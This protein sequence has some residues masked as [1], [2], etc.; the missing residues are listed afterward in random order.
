MAFL[1]LVIL[2][3]AGFVAYKV[4]Q[5]APQVTAK[6]EEIS[7]TPLAKELKEVSKEIEKAAEKPVVAKK[8]EPSVKKVSKEGE[9]TAKKPK[10]K[11]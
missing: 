6:I 1:I 10:Q 2:V 9:N 8:V 5:K 4:S 7:E 11:K 3:V